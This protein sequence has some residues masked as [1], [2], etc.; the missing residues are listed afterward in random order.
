M[1]D[2]AKPEKTLRSG[3]FDDKR[4][5]TSGHLRAYDQVRTELGGCEHLSINYVLLT[6]KGRPHGAALLGWHAREQT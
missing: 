3:I 6:T 4:G 1:F 2:F 5:F